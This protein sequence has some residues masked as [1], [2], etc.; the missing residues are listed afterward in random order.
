MVASPV[1]DPTPPPYDIEVWRKL[2]FPERMR[3]V[4][5]AWVTQGYGTPVV[6]YFLYLF[7][8][9]FIYIGGWWLFCWFTPGLGGLAIQEWAFHDEA[10]KKAVVWTLAY[11]GLGLGCASGPLTGR[12]RPPI[13]GVL[14]FLRPGTTKMPF[15]P[16]IP[17]FGGMR[18]TVLDAALYAVHYGFLFRTLIAPEVTPELL[19]PTLVLLPILGI[20]DK[21]I[22][23]S[24]RAEHHFTAIVCLALATE[25][26]G[27]C[28]VVWM[29]IWLWAATSKLNHHFPSVICV[30]LS[31]SPVIPTWLKRRLYVDY[32]KD[33]RPSRLAHMMAHGGTVTEYTFPWLLLVGDGGTLTIVALFVMVGF[34][35]FITS[36][37]PM[38]VPLEWNFVMVYGAFFLFG[39][40]ADASVLALSGDL[41]VVGYL[42]LV[43]FVVPLVGNLVP[44]RVSFLQSMRYYAGNWAY[45]IWLFRGESSKKLDRLTKAAP[46]VQD[47]LRDSID[48]KTL[49]QQMSR[50]PA[51]RLM[52][53]HG[54][55]LHDLLPKAVD[56]INEYEWME[57]E[58]VAGLAL[59]WNFGDGHLH[60]TRLLEAI[61][62]Q[63]HF[64]RGELRIICVESQPLG[65]PSHRWVI[66]DAVD[67]VLERGETKVAPL[68]ERQPYPVA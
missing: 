21:A 13:G 64:E 39:R 17:L 31:N 47:Q 53:L 28:K 34:H 30:M 10:F 68:R 48:E 37:M 54:R 65:G 22:F 55:V 41:V 25:W 29:A 3:L 14:H 56:D 11:E 32:P 63:C 4:C 35:T 38:G 2:P 6:V 44:S 5:E 7:K 19:F 67:G 18:R 9:L 15:A 23:L 45:S 66:A 57:G 61:Q 26:I 33:I 50:L 42:A 27:G 60:D 40:H 20:T 49:E 36:N 59:G 12:Y 1:L 43:L 58:I 52:H 8:I 51:F 62:E 24:A 46:R 16:G